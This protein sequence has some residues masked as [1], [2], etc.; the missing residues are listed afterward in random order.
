MAVSIPDAWL[1]KVFDTFEV[2]FVHDSYLAGVH[3]A[4]RQDLAEELALALKQS[5]TVKLK[6]DAGNWK[7][8]K[9]WGEGVVGPRKKKIE[10]LGSVG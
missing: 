1:V 10:G 7:L 2:L 3:E 4:E 5:L 9:R 6:L 8:G